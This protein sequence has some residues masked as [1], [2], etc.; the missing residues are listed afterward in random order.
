MKLLFIFLTISILGFGNLK[1]QNQ[2]TDSIIGELLNQNDILE[3]GRVYP[4]L[5]KEVHPFLQSMSEALLA[6]ALNRPTE[7]CASID[8]LMKSYQNMMDFPTI[9]NMLYLWANNLQLLGMYQEATDLLDGF[10]KQIPA[11]YSKNITP[12]FNTTIRYCD[13]LKKYPQS[14]IYQGTNED[15]ALPIKISSILERGVLISIPAVINNVTEY[16]VFDTGAE[17]NAVSEDF[18]KKHQIKVI[19]DSIVTVGVTTMYSK[20]GL[21]DSLKIGTIVYK[22]IPVNILPPS[23]D[24]AIFETNAILGLPFLKA[25]K[26]VRIRPDEKLMIIPYQSDLNLEPNI[27]LS[28]NQLCVEATIKGQ[29]CLLNFDTGSISSY[30][31]N[32]YF[33]M[34]TE[35]IETFGNRKRLL[36]GGFGMLDSIDAY[37]IP[38]NRVEVGGT[39]FE[40][41]LLDVRKYDNLIDQQ[42]RTVGTLGSDLLLRCKEIIINVEKMFV[43]FLESDTKTSMAAPTVEYI[44]IPSLNALMKREALDQSQ[45]P[46]TSSLPLREP[47]LFYRLNK[48]W[49]N[50]QKMEYTFDMNTMKWQSYYAN[51]LIRIRA[52]K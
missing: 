23:P 17:G 36:A 3:L 22:N 26:E 41:L 45:L 37:Q 13:I 31:N 40:N 21:I 2:S 33:K 34:N 5:Q 46:P 29:K 8:N 9:V 18:A 19:G 32:E 48:K 11:E 1:A 43:I 38:I 51:K 10:L 4:K 25:V 39:F 52:T 35:Y 14:K 50:I 15:Y 24:D 20:L 27:V 6:N 30:L 47:T 7:A 44:R 28:N 16:F 42:S 12:L 49:G